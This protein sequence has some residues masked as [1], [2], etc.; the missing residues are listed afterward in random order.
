MEDNGS[1]PAEYK[2]EIMGDTGIVQ[3]HLAVVGRPFEVKILP[4]D[5]N[6]SCSPWTVR[7]INRYEPKTLQTVLCLLVT[8]TRIFRL[9]CVQEFR[10]E[11][12]DFQD[13][14]KVHCKGNI[15]QSQ[16]GDGTYVASLV[17][18]SE[19][20]FRVSITRNGKN[21]LRSPF[22]VNAE[23]GVLTKRSKLSLIGSDIE[24]MRSVGGVLQQ[25]IDARDSGVALWGVPSLTADLPT[26][27]TLMLASIT[28]GGIYI[29]VWDACCGNLSEENLN[30]W[31]YLLSLQAPSA[32]VILL[33][34][35]ISATHANE[36]DLKPFQNVNPMM[37]RSI[38]VG[39]TFASEP[40]RLLDE[41]LLVV[42]ET[43]YHQNLV[44]YRLESLA[45]KVLQM[46][47]SRIELLDHSTFKCIA[48]ECGIQRD[49]LTRKAAEHLESTGMGLRLGGDSFFFV[50]Q[51]LWLARHLTEIAGSSPFGASERNTLGKTEN[52]DPLWI[53]YDTFM[54]LKV[55]FSLNFTY[56][57]GK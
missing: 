18:Y 26:Q 3:H 12:I 7:A 17:F 48:G 50:L 1:S 40:S 51:P 14:K 34:V 23:K 24:C 15:K 30:V 27:E 52:S 38:F 33:G 13:S 49:F 22:K 21:V 20:S 42:S 28:D 44:W 39:T 8:Q 57:W 4:R 54:F 6:T 16:K 35:N 32:N 2:V 31:L 29:Y 37:K 41:V 11:A 5:G 19:G 43:N 25:A 47:R 36:I 45:S 9:L 55:C 56:A 10:A 53:W 46:K